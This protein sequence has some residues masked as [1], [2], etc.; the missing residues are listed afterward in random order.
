[1]RHSLSALVLT[2]AALTAGCDSP[3]GP[4]GSEISVSAQRG[5]IALT[6]HGDE[7][8][9]YRLVERTALP[10]VSW[11]LCTRP[12]SCAGVAPGETLRLPY[13]RIAGYDRGDREALVMTHRLEAGPDGEYVTTGSRTR[14]VRLR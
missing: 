14:T 8:V 3:S 4:D 12:E 5:V 9:Y 10:A 1:M 7:P 11:V 2:A 6:N 13:E